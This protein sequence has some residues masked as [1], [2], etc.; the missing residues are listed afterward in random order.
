MNNAE[1]LQLLEDNIDKSE[2]GYGDIHTEYY[3]KTL[4]DIGINEVKHIETREGNLNDLYYCHT[5]YYFPEQDVYVKLK[6]FFN[7]YDGMHYY[8]D[9]YRDSEKYEIVK[10]KQVTYTDYE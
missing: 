1:F 8:N 7:S 10:P 9:E 5:I 4:T 3:K 6:G 2:F